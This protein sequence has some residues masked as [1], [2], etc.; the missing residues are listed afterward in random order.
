MEYFYEIG[1]PKFVNN[2]KNKIFC[3]FKFTQENIFHTL[4]TNILNNNEINIL[5]FDT[6]LAYL[7][8]SDK[9]PFNILYEVLD[10]HT[11]NLYTSLNNK[12][13]S[14]SFNNN[15]F[16]VCYNNYI[17]SCILIKKLF[18]KLNKYCIST[19]NKPSN[20]VYIISNYCFYKNII[21]N[22]FSNKYI[23]DY[24]K[25]DN[26]NEIIN[27]IKIFGFYSNFSNNFKSE[28]LNIINSNFDFSN[29]DSNII[30][31]IINEIDSNIRNFKI[32]EDKIKQTV[33]TIKIFSQ[34]NNLNF[35]NSYKEKMIK[36]LLENYNIEI[37]NK[38]LNSL[39]Y[40]TNK[41]LYI[42]MKLLVDDYY[43]SKIIDD[44]FKKQKLI[45][46]LKNIKI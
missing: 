9:N 8:N 11:T 3:N 44:M 6:H 12:I 10:L 39:V 38:L 45:F 1:M 18:Y 30:N 41:E 37:E 13:I 16:I 25:Y 40:N 5:E 33:E 24:I 2:L 22:K 19:K 4:C 35:L 17:K 14:N 26:I 21:N 36:R 29:I 27:L 34:Q 20:I 7:I 23:Q 46:N 43:Q 31:K 42:H 32:E 28:K 15:D